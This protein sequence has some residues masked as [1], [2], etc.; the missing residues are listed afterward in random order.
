MY[1]KMLAPLNKKIKVV[2]SENAARRQEDKEDLLYNFEKLGKVAGIILNEPKIQ[3]VKEDLLKLTKEEI[4]KKYNE[5]DVRKYLVGML[6]VFGNGHCPQISVRMTVKEFLDAKI[7]G[8]GEEETMIAKV[9]NHKTMHIYGKASVPF[10]LED[11][12]Q[13]AKH[14]FHIFREHLVSL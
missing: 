4:L 13:A 10:L 9:S 8:E 6:V 14:Y 12:Y 5:I 1:S 3:K 2:T 11:L 7:V